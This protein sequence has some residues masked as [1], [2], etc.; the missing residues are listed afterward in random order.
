MCYVL[1]STHSVIS[2]GMGAVLSGCT[3]MKL[4]TI[5]VSVGCASRWPKRLDAVDEVVLFST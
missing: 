4:V 2:A 3:R 5:G 1:R